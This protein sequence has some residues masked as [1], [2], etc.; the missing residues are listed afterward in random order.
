M[1]DGRDSCRVTGRQSHQR[2]SFQSNIPTS[3]AAIAISRV[4]VFWTDNIFGKICRRLHHHTVSYFLSERSDVGREV[5]RGRIMMMWARA[6]ATLY[7][8]LSAHLVAAGR[9]LNAPLQRLVQQQQAY[10]DESTEEEHTRGGGG[11][12][13]RG[14]EQHSSDSRRASSPPQT[15][16]R[17]ASG[18]GR[19]A[20][21]NTKQTS[22]PREFAEDT[23]ARKQWMVTQR[24]RADLLALHYTASEVAAIDPEVAAVVISRGL[25]RPRMGMP[26]AWKRRNGKAGLGREA[27]PLGRVIGGVFNALNPLPMIRGVGSAVGRVLSSI[28]LSPQRV[29][30]F[31]AKALAAGF[32]ASQLRNALAGNNGYGEGSGFSLP[33]LPGLPRWLKPGRNPDLEDDDDFDEFF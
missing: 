5:C 8:L 26:P 20:A 3:R 11:G 22:S 31:V 15:R 17:A 25:S 30:S 21:G 24:M 4:Y 14:A 18:R 23:L 32:L 1:V 27:G 28:G 2:S 12:A 7:L 6:V 10:Y 9:P 16:S 33:Q 13:S 29:F 19:A